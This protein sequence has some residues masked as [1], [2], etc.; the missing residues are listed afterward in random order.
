MR[1]VRVVQRLLNPLTVR[2][3]GDQM[4]REPQDLLKMQAFEIERFERLKWGIVERAA[5]RKAA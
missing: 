5:A 1:A 4:L 3:E 2:F